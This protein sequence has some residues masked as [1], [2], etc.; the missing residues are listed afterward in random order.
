M[1]ILVLAG[2]LSP[3][4]SVSLASGHAVCTALRGLGHRSVVI[5]LFLGLDPMVASTDAVFA[6]PMADGAAIDST[7]PD[8]QAVRNCRQ[9]AG[10]GRIGAGVLAACARADLVFLALHGQDGEDGRVQAML[11]L[12]E[13]PYTGSGYLASAM[14]M[15]KV[16]SKKMMDT[17]G[18]PTPAWEQ[19]VYTKADIPQLA[20]RL[21]LPCVIKA[22]N[23]GSSLGVYL[24]ESRE[25]LASALEDVR[26]FNATVL[27]EQR[28]VGRE[29]T[30]G[31]LGETA[32]PPVEILG[33]F[34]YEGKYQ[35]HGA[36]EVCPAELTPEQSILAGKYALQLHHALG[37]SGYSRTDLM[38]DEDG[39]FWCLEVNSLPGMTAMS[40]LPKE[41]AAVGMGYEQLCQEIVNQAMKKGDTAL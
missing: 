18:I 32:L 24:P 16:I 17:A 11:D 28:I 39:K 37:L 4:R 26:R 6:L 22:A 29:F 27:M 33:N 15:D 34:D 3:E 20:S 9:F 5:D 13:I 14:A 12:M 38:L 25:A 36:Q 31:V 21:A 35:A 19:L 40:L 10:S 1:K 23:G 41:A 2:G 30:V 8:L 7:A